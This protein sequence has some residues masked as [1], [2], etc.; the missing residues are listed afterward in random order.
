MDHGE[1]ERKSG[2]EPEP[3][4]RAARRRRPQSTRMREKVA[5]S[6]QSEKCPLALIG[7]QRRLCYRRPGRA[8]QQ[9]TLE[10]PPNPVS[11]RFEQPV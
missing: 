4:C 1:R 9:Y 2:E 10:Q 5:P 7:T 6:S 3:G 8:L 11:L